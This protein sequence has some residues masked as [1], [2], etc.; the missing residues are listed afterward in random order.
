MSCES[1]KV[2]L[3]T[4]GERLIKV[5]KDLREFGDP[6]SPALA[7]GISVAQVKILDVLADSEPTTINAIAQALGLTPPTVSVAVGKLERMDLVYQKSSNDGRPNLRVISMGGKEI[8]QKIHE[9]RVAKIQSLLLPLTSDERES[10]LSLLE[11]A[12]AGGATSSLSS[13]HPLETQ[14]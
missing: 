12:V 13:T 1:D 3:M 2:F 7:H 4:Q 8:Q 6:E 10:L 9:Y 11:K 14:G 5:L